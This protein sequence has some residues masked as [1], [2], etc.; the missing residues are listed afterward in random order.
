MQIALERDAAA[1]NAPDRY[2]Y[3]ELALLHD[4]RGDA[5]AAAAARARA[6]ELAK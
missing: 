1:A 6:Q 5:A 2:V 3:E 4:A